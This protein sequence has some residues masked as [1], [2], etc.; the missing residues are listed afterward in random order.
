M[1]RIPQYAVPSAYVFLDALPLNASNKV[2][3]GRLP[4]PD[5]SIVR[6]G[7]PVEPQDEL[8]R[9]ILAIWTRELQVDDAGMTDNFFYFGGDSLS[10]SSLVDQLRERFRVRLRLRDLFTEPTPAAL[11]ARIRAALE[12]PR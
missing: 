2:D 1:R 4:P 7:P 8:E 10:A 3:R 11:A 9:E 5:W 12:R 6:V